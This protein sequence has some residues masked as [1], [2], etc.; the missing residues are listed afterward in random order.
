MKKRMPKHQRQLNVSKKGGTST[1]FQGG[2]KTGVQQ[3]D[4]QQQNEANVSPKRRGVIENKGTT[5]LRV[6]RRICI[7]RQVNI[8]SGRGPGKEFVGLPLK[9]VRRRL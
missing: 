1:E 8:V 6:K 3:G 7:S 4:P 9:L 2:G 5:I